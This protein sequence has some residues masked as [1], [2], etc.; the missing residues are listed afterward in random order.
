L[1]KQ[2]LKRKLDAILERRDA[3]LPATKKTNVFILDDSLG[4][5]WITK[6]PE[7]TRR[8]NGPKD[9]MGAVHQQ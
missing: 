3:A 8:A 7:N 4:I 9:T 5:C 6:A 2:N 1:E